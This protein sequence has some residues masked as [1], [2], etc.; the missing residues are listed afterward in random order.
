ML[1]DD[2]DAGYVATTCGDQFGDNGE[3][4]PCMVSAPPPPEPVPGEPWP[5]PPPPEPHGPWTPPAP[6]PGHLDECC[7]THTYGAAGTYTARFH[8][9]SYTSSY[10]PS[11][12]QWEVPGYPTTDFDFGYL[13]THD[14]YANQI[15]I[16]A[17]VTVSGPP[18]TTTT[19][20]APH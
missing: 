6:L 18:V 16:T 14:P 7:V 13:V 15:D 12:A 3:D 5:P 8:V 9:Q 11:P 2:P 1:A 10:G 19:T 4:F 20:A 17:T